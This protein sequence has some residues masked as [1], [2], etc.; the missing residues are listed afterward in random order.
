MTLVWPDHEMLAGFLEEHSLHAA[1]NPVIIETSE[2]LRNFGIL[3]SRSSHPYLV[4]LEQELIIFLDKFLRPLHQAPAA[5]KEGRALVQG[6]RRDVQDVVC[7]VRAK[8]PGLLCQERQWDC[9]I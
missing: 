2:V 6:L 4:R 3:D 1:G 8:T 5:N 9:F 7:P